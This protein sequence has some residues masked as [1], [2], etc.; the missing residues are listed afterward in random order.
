MIKHVDEMLKR[1][2]IYIVMGKWEVFFVE[3]ERGTCY[4]LKPTDYSRDGELVPT[5]WNHQRIHEIHG[6]FGRIVV[7]RTG[8]LPK[9]SAV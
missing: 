6:P 8:V 1:D 9:T 2:G 7:D 4:Q 3:V 5:G